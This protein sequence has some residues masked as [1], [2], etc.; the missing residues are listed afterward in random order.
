MV[1]VALARTLSVLLRH[2][3]PAYDFEHQVAAL[4]AHVA[5]I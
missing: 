4:I 1:R 2:G 5:G 3:K